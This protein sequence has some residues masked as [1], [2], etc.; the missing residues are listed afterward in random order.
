MS[1]IRENARYGSISEGGITFV[2]ADA[3]GRRKLRLTPE[4]CIQ[5]QFDL[6][7][8]IL[9]CLDDCPRPEA[10]EREVSESV[11]R[12]VLWAARCKREF[13][14]QLEIR[15][16]GA[17]ERPVLYGIIQGGYVEAARRY[18]AEGLLEI[19]FDGYGFGG[20]PLDLD[21]NLAVDTLAYTASLMPDR[22]PKYALGV[23][24]PGN[25]VAC[26]RM[27]YA[28]YDCVL[29][30]RDARHQRLYCEGE[31]AG[32]SLGQ[33]GSS[34]LYIQDDKYKRDPRPVSE[35]CDCYCCAHYS[36]SYLHHLFGVQD[37]LAY[38]LAT[39]HNLRFYVRLMESL[40]QNG[41]GRQEGPT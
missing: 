17:G 29:P 39:I 31:P 9:I 24:S 34:F 23:G 18:C 13:E 1:M 36:R 32:V 41:D 25:I 10:D 2:N 20:W 12:T 19:G 38:R 22:L 37:T 27:G 11:R 7:S 14:R 21:G 4:K 3:P 35:A 6:G 5:I 33:H 30:T 40:R 16:L 8:D 15:Q 28:I 26:V